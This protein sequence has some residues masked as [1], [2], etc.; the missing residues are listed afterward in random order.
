MR[1]LYYAFLLVIAI[2]V[3]GC[4]G[5]A[6]RGSLANNFHQFDNQIDVRL[7]G[8]NEPAV[9]EAFGK[10]VGSAEGVVEASRYGMTIVPDNPQ[11][12]FVN[13][14]VTVNGIDS[15]TLQTTIMDMSR[16]LIRAGGLLTM[17]GVPYNYTKDEIGLLYGLRPGDAT[18]RK[19]WFLID[20]DL[21]RER[22]MSGW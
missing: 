7:D 2:T 10:I 13:W 5:K 9:A 6:E 3:C 1:H 16:E 19:L 8:A 17:E 11:A 4:A 15:F 12:S 18:S 21:A 14:R 20:R 22:E